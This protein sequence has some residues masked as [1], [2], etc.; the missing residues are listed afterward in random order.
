MYIVIIAGY[1]LT[2]ICIVITASPQHVYMHIH[3]HKITGKFF[4]DCPIFFLLR[5]KKT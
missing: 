2:E 4:I 3:I 5:A 1:Q